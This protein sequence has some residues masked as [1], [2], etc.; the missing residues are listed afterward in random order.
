MAAQNFGMPVGDVT[1]DAPAKKLPGD[2]Y[3]PSQ[4]RNARNG[5]QAFLAALG[6]LGLVSAAIPAAAY[7]PQVFD[8]SHDIGQDF[9]AVPANT[10]PLG[11]G[12]MNRNVWHNIFWSGSAPQL[13]FTGS[14]GL[15]ITSQASLN[16][17]STG[18]MTLDNSCSAG[19][20]FG[21]FHWR[22]A[23]GSAKMGPGANEIMW[24]ADG[25]PAWPG[26]IKGSD[27]NHISEVDVLETNYGSNGTEY[28]TFHFYN[29][30]AAYHSGQMVHNPISFPA[31]SG[32][33][34]AMHD[35]DVVWGPGSLVVKVDGVV[36][37][38]APPTQVRND[39][40]HG[41]CNY[42][43]G[44]QEA[45]QA[46]SLDKTPSVALQI[47]NIWWSPTDGSAGSGTSTPIAAPAPTPPAS[48]QAPV[49][50]A[51]LTGSLP[52]PLLTGTQTVSGKGGKAGLQLERISQGSYTAPGSSGWV[53]ATVQADGSWTASLVF[54][55]A[56]TLAHVFAAQGGSTAVV[57]LVDG[58]PAAPP[59]S[60]VPAPTPPATPVPAGL[61]ISS[62]VKNG[63]LLLMTGAKQIGKA[64]TLREYMDGK[65]LGTLRDNFADGPFSMHIAA[66]AAG[67]HNL[68][69]TLDGSTATASFAFTD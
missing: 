64:A 23:I 13:Q 22:S 30:A 57:D 25:D 11:S 35:Y 55:K 60:T 49:P 42:T 61:S 5:R 40:A 52:S 33:M 9:T 41:G 36:Q 29:G 7:Q 6:S 8:P 68:K 20:G 63:G 47:A 67:S 59:A 37:M 24:P 43:I 56:G 69:L 65:Y 50:A 19:F 44:A 32:D 4:G 17:P 18:F 16:W 3:S 10:A 14:T 26:I 54:D 2:S 15:L 38:S 66:T 51:V 39:Y 48:T 27:D 1:P 58:T 34:T 53:K 28:S 46:T 62:V 31:G 45:M 21:D 12:G